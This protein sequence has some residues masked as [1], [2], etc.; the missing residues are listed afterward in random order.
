MLGA[1]LGAW[2]I[3]PRPVRGTQD[4]VRRCLNMLDTQSGLSEASWL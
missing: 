3:A 2:G 4:V 1:L